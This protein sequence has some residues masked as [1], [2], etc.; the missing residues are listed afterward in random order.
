MSDAVQNKALKS[1]LMMTCSLVTL[2]APRDE[3]DYD[4][5][6]ENDEPVFSSGHEPILVW[7]GPDG[8]SILAMKGRF[9]IGFI[10]KSE[11]IEH[12]HQIEHA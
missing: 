12:C 4:E 10:R 11:W 8:Q 3:D 5:G 1:R 9:V 2:P 6:Q 7:R